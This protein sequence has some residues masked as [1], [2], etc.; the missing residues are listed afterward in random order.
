M[1]VAPRAVFFVDSGSFQAAYQAATLGLTARAMGDEVTW[2]LGFDGLTRW[3]DGS[4]G[5]A[6]SNAEQARVT[7]AKELSLPAPAAM[8]DQGRAAGARVVACETMIELCGLRRDEVERAV[9]EILGLPTIWRLCQGA[10][11]VTLT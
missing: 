3:V 11:A 5:A 10:T 9:D 8:I 6:V 4:F 2:V 7:R 1:G